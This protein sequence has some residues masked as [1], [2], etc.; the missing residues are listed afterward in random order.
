[1]QTCTSSI[2]SN[3]GRQIGQVCGAN[4]YWRK[5]HYPWTKG[6]RSETYRFHLSGCST[7]QSAFG[8]RNFSTNAISKDENGTKVLD[9]DVETMSRNKLLAVL[10]EVLAV[11]TLSKN[12]YKKFRVLLPSGVPTPDFEAEDTEGKRTRVEVKNLRAPKD[13]VRTVV[14]AH[15]RKRTAEHPKRYCFKAVL[16]YSHRGS[17]SSEAITRLSAIIDVLPETKHPVEEILAGGVKIRIEKAEQYAQHV[18]RRNAVLLDITGKDKPGILI[19]SGMNAGHLAT[20]LSEVQSLFL[21]AVRRVVECTPKFFGESFH[22]GVDDVNLIAMRWEP[23]E[24]IASAEM[25]EH[26]ADQIGGLFTSFQLPLKLVIFVDP[27]IEWEL[28]K[29]YS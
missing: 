4:K 29:K 13:I 15:W 21:K 7:S 24:F 23:P 26:I 9:M 6:G 19:L 22:A 10:A 8:F 14:A 27:E 17:L 12:G 11:I 25:M 28:I 18:G 1:M 20:E 3:E 2:C 5:S 16:T